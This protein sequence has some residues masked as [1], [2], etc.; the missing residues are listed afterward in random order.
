MERIGGLTISWCKML[1]CIQKIIKRGKRPKRPSPK[2]K[3]PWANH[4]PGFLKS[5]YE[6]IDGYNAE[7]RKERIRK[8]LKKDNRGQ[9]AIACSIK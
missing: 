1:S 8:K 3:T 5:N 2:G 4:V 9:S 6:S 7:L